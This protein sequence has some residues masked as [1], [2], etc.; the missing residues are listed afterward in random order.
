MG[1]QRD[2][3]NTSSARLAGSRGSRHGSCGVQRLALPLRGH[4]GL[5]QGATLDLCGAV[6]DGAVGADLRDRLQLGEGAVRQHGQALLEALLVVLQAP[7]G[8][9]DSGYSALQT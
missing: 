2:L 1:D 7:R 9:L 3:A 6:R 4:E 5:A 8:L